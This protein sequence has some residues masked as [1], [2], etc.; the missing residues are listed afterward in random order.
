MAANFGAI[1]AD[2]YPSE[3]NA[4]IRWFWDNGFELT[5]GDEL[6]GI[7]AE[8]TVRTIPAAAEWFVNAALQNF[9][10]TQF[11]SKY[12]F[13]PVTLIYFSPPLIRLH[14]PTK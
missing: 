4:T 5:L 14:A 12:G 10:T 1:L 2:L 6:N 11:A 8:T 7:V 3:I 9:P 13:P